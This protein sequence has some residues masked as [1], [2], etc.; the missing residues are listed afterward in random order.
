[1]LVRNPYSTH[2]IEIGSSQ[3]LA[4][5]PPRSTTSHPVSS[6]RPV[7]SATRRIGRHRNPPERHASSG[8][9]TPRAASSSSRFQAYPTIQWAR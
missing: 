8:G 1:M 2:A 7:L 9:P 6:N 5:I 3:R 4:S